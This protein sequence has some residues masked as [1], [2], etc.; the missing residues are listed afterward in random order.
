MT[1][2]TSSETRAPDEGGAA[3]RCAAIVPSVVRSM[4][5][6]GSRVARSRSDVV[7]CKIIGGASVTPAA[8]SARA[9]A[10]PGD[11]LPLG[12]GPR[13]VEVTVAGLLAWSFRL[14]VEVAFTDAQIEADP[15]LV[16]TTVLRRGESRR[17]TP[18]Y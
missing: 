17:D 12:I 15:D 3:S 18:D 14:P 2:V 7:A 16:T 11:I 8:P 5:V 6:H 10:A 4:F 9:V 13:T 1:R